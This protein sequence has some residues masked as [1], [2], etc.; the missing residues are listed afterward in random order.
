MDIGHDIEAAQGRGVW[1]DRGDRVVYAMDDR[2]CQGEDE[3]GWTMGG[4]RTWARSKELEA[5]E[6]WIVE[7][8]G[9]GQCCCSCNYMRG[10]RSNARYHDKVAWIANVASA[11][12]AGGRTAALFRLRVVR[13]SVRLAGHQ[14]EEKKQ[15]EQPWA[16][17]SHRQASK[18]CW[19]VLV[20]GNRRSI[21][22]KFPVP[23]TKVNI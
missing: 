5:R 8:A 20:L 13:I 22:R 16:Q 11:L 19:T 2:A 18:Q 7:P 4:H 23:L 1:S 15:Q 9:E 14:T 3:D 12:G 10:I 21:R 6:G 17:D